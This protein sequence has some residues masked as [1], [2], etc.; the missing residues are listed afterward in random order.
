MVVRRYSFFIHVSQTHELGA[1]AM[2]HQPFSILHY[3]PIH[4]I[5][6]MMSAGPLSSQ[7]A[8]GKKI[9]KRS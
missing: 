3:P 6:P 2:V 5:M 7:D 1:S 8:G 4:M 9:Y